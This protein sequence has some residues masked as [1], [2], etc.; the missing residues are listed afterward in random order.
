MGEE[1]ANRMR[2]QSWDCVLLNGK[3]GLSGVDL[4]SSDE[5]FNIES[6]LGWSLQKKSGICSCYPGRGGHYHVVNHGRQPPA[7]ESGPK[8]SYSKE[9]RTWVIQPQGHEFR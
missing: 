1:P 2:Y 8:S 5:A 6:F 4:A 9:I 7:A 3:G